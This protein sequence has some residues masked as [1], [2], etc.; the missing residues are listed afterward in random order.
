MYASRCAVAEVEGARIAVL[1]I[2][3]LTYA[4][5]TVQAGGVIS[6]CISIVTWE[7]DGGGGP[8]I[9][10]RIRN[11]QIIGAHIG[12]VATG[13]IRTA[14]AL[15]AGQRQIAETGSPET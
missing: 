11:T 8:K 13:R 6:T 15:I 9:E 10:A 1:A 7:T 5:C 12:I 4:T 3:G 14:S 2:N